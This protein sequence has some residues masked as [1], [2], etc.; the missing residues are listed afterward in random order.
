MGTWDWDILTNA[1]VWSPGLE[2]IHGMAEGTF[3]QTFAA[4]LATI[5]P[6]DRD[7]FLHTISECL[8][9]DKEYHIE[10]RLLWPDGSVHWIEGRGEVFHDE[11]GKPVRMMGLGMD[12]DE[13]KR[14]ENTLRFLADASAALAVVVDY[15][16]TLRR[17]AHLAVPFFAD[18]CPVD[19]ADGAGSTRRLAVAH[20]DPSKVNLARTGSSLSARSQCGARCTPGSAPP[21]DPNS[22]PTFPTAC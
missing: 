16:S 13:R 1:V 9:L 7:R 20:V 14:T 12:I 18:W 22:C 21:A 15:E 4:V 19:L 3:E 11:V 2:A 8:Q 5:H 10:Y 6:E 17:V